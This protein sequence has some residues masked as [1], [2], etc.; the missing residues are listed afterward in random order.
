MSW[1]NDPELREIA[2]E[3]RQARQE[4]LPVPAAFEA[5]LRRQLEDKASMQTMRFSDRLATALATVAIVVLAGLFWGVIRPKLPTTEA[6]PTNEVIE[7]S[8]ISN[9]TATETPRQES[10]E[11]SEEQW[12]TYS[13]YHDPYEIEFA[14]PDS[15]QATFV[16]GFNRLT[17]SATYNKFNFKITPID[18]TEPSIK[19]FPHFNESTVRLEIATQEML[20]V[21]VST[22]TKWEAIEPFALLE[23]YPTTMLGIYQ[24]EDDIVLLGATVVDDIEPYKVVDV[25]ARIAPDQLDEV[26]PIFEQVL[27]TIRPASLSAPKELKIYDNYNGWVYDGFGVGYSF[28]YPPTWLLNNY[29]DFAAYTQIKFILD[30]VNFS[31]EAL[32]NPDTLEEIDIIG[33]V[34]FISYPQLR[35]ML[36]ASGQSLDTVPEDVF[37]TIL[38]LPARGFSPGYT[39]GQIEDIQ[40]VELAGYPVIIGTNHLISTQGSSSGTQFTRTHALIYLP[41]SVLTISMKYPVDIAQEILQE[42]L[43]SLRPIDD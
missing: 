1:K 6:P 21:Y 32:R 26:R 14:Y 27:Q 18:G 37:A 9:L 24:V 42:L 16:A 36:E 23:Q 3:L 31:S 12:L 13:S 39:Q 5:R 11:P 40:V 19:I 28:V 34:T 10:V 41:D 20:A 4:N 35:S 25:W 29:D 17:G 30:P 33:K 8:A 22:A 7:I 38:P 43:A 2:N 15:W